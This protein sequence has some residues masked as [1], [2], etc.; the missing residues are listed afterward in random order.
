MWWI[1]ILFFVLVVSTGALALL[2]WQSGNPR[3]WRW[4]K[5]VWRGGFVVL[6]CL[7]LFFFLSRLAR[8]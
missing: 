6:L 2:G 3:Y 1:R 4:L 8:L 5:L 7:M